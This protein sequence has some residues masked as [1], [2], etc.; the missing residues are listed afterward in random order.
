MAAPRAWG[1]AL[2]LYQDVLVPVASLLLVPV[3]CLLR[4]DVR[5]ASGAGEE[6]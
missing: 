2:D 6:L 5:G 1:P 3:T 4:P